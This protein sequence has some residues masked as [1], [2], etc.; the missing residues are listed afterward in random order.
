MGDDFLLGMI[1]LT[2]LSIEPIKFS[3]FN[4]MLVYSNV[5]LIAVLSKVSFSYC[6]PPGK[7]ISP[8]K[9]SLGEAFLWRNRI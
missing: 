9:R 8:E 5:S 1:K 2:C 7:Q 4:M 3:L 6:L